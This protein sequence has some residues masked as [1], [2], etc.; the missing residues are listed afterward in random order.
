[1]SY[2]AGANARRRKIAPQRAVPLCLSRHRHHTCAASFRLRARTSNRGQKQCRSS[3]G[4][5][6]QA[7]HP[8]RRS[9]SAAP[10]RKSRIPTAP[11]SSSWKTSPSPSTGARWRPTFSPRNI[12]ARPACRPASSASRR[13]KS[14]PGCGA[15]VPTSAR[16]PSGPSK[17]ATSARPT[18]ARCS[19]ASPAH[20]PTG[21]GR[22]AI[23]PART[24][25]APSSTSTATC[26]PCSSARRTA[27]NGSTPACTGP[28]AS[29]ARAR[30]T[31]T[32]I[33]S[34]AS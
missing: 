27:R 31:T 16:L 29:T 11:S 9:R 8:T 34:P 14:R 25:R 24:M 3:G 2:E 6:R 33:T 5:R 1:M 7:N 13:R 21:A 23:S 10:P 15:R 30:A 26:W 18:P 20:G 4:S 22:A 28:T 12:S 17:T 19:T 32:S